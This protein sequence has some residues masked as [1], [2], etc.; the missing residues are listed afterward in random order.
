MPS[1]N[2]YLSNLKF[3]RKLLSS[4]KA[5]YLSNIRLVILLVIF[6]LVAGISSFLRLPKRLN[7]EIKIPIVSVTTVL[8]GAG[9][10]DVESL[11]TIPIEDKL[12]SV[13][14]KTDMDSVS[15]E[16]VSNITL[17]FTSGTD[18]EKAKQDVKSALDTVTNL[19][20]DAKTPIVQ[21]FDFENQPVWIFALKTTSD[22]ATLSRFADTIEAKLKESS[23]I[24]H[25]GISGIDKQEF[26]IL[27]KP[28]TLE[29][30]NINPQQVSASIR[31]SLKSYPGGDVD[32]GR[33]SFPIGVDAF[34]TDVTNLRLIP[35][36][37]AGQIV[38]LGDI[39]NISEKAVP[40]QNQAYYADKNFPPQRVVTFSVFKT[41]S[42]NIT[43]A[44][45]TAKD[46]VNKVVKPY[47]G[48]FKL[49]TVQDT[50][51]EV[52]KQFNDLTSNF[53][54]TIILVFITFLIFLGIRQALIVS[55][56]IPL[57]FLSAFTIM[58]YLGLSI[59]FLS[60]FSLL[61]SLGLLVD[62]S[63]VIITGITSYYKTRKFTPQE[64]G[65]LVWRD[66]IIP[67]WSTTITTVWAF[68]PL[69]LSTGIIGE[70]IKTI[71]IV[72]AATLYSSTAIAVL[73]TLPLMMATLKLRIP[74]RVKLLLQTLGVVLL[75]FLVYP[76]LSKNPLAPIIIIFYLAFIFVTFRIRNKI[77]EATKS[78]I[79]TRNRKVYGEFFSRFL[80]R[81]LIDLEE[82]GAKYKNVISRILASK[83]ARRK[84]II[85]IVLFTVFAYFL[86]PAGF[87]VNEFFP[88]SKS[89]LLFITEELPAGTKLE[90]TNKEAYNLANDLRN[91]NGVN[92]VTAEVGSINGQSG[93]GGQSGSNVLQVTLNLPDPNDQ[94]ISSL[95]I[96][97]RLRDKYKNQT[98]KGLVSVVEEN[99]GPPAGADLQIQVL[100]DDLQKL[101]LYADKI[102]DYLKSQPGVVN[103]NKSIKPGVSKLTF[104]PDVIKLSE[105][106]LNIDSTGFA[107]RTYSTGTTVDSVKFNN[108]NNSEDIILREK[109][110]NPTPQELGTLNINN[111]TGEQ[112][113]I[114]ALGNFQLK[115]NPTQITRHNNKRTISVTAGITKGYSVTG[116]NKK[117]EKFADSLNLPEGY[118][119]QTGGV[120]EENNKSVQSI[121]QAMLLA[122]ILIFGTMVIQ[123]TSYRQALLVMLI[124]P[125]A[126]SGV[127]VIFALTGT[128]L[129]FPALI[130]VLSLFGIVVTQ[131]MVLVDRIN[132]NRKAGLPFSS[133]ISDAAAARLEPIFL[134]SFTTIVGL[135]PITISNPLWRGLGG[136]IVAGLSFSIFIMLF[137]IPVVYYMW[138][139]PVKEV[140]RTIIRT[141]AKR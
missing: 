5:K 47:N 95:D 115:T 32:T 113:P 18:P 3:D 98:T 99:G 61:L 4:F 88:K 24:D 110:G 57:T 26:Q 120:N 127:F 125:I 91:T 68:I 134:G 29:Q 102:G 34:T 33:F 48:D 89:N 12:N 90:V 27:L 79:S 60:L 65:L 112:I 71:P 14:G 49:I 119:W 23:K 44:S 45:D 37:L 62:D 73:I 104:I 52:N 36:N 2:S 25:V 70:F 140:T 80:S 122:G 87:V 7:P 97:E 126:I 17:Q 121:F 83:S 131:A 16:S 58:Y 100:G 13:A 85:A 129:S 111:M 55:L 108:S 118:S 101:D 107:L 92:Y 130:G 133:A 136:A 76:L 69:L 53:K 78:R 28:E 123:F 19:P 63:I 74:N 35:V 43:E 9:P 106:G 137:F 72:V 67:I 54:D 116:T 8:P 81:G 84:T 114:A 40:N 94:K 11:V 38:K 21:T 135:V 41:R 1:K 93:Q 20:T 117:L 109:D 139:N 10:K 42:A 56:T 124:I 39:A 75:I 132:L 30:Y 59:N 103:I 82:V 15:G 64:A 86:V 141:R 6:I 31:A 66:F 128:P 22:P 50:A 77:F 46:I 105:N 51:N 138:F 96:A